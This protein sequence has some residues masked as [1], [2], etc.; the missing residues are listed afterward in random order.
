MIKICN[1]L[2][3]DLPAIY[4]VVVDLLIKKGEV[5]IVD[6]NSESGNFGRCNNGI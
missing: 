4:K 2:Y 5:C 6:E 3:V 1:E